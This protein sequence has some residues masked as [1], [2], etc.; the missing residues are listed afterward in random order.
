MEDVRR[1][2]SGVKMNRMMGPP[3]LDMGGPPLPPLKPVQ[4]LLAALGDPGQVESYVAPLLFFLWGT[5]AE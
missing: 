3:S 1:A 2:W 5:S 4:P